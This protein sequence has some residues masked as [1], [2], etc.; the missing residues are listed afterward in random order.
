M[1]PSLARV[2]KVGSLS[3]RSERQLPTV[4]RSP[5]GSRGLTTGVVGGLGGC[6]TGRQH[7]QRN[8]LFFFFLNKWTDELPCMGVGHSNVLEQVV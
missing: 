5:H 4:T 7:L 2:S 1:T 8:V 3:S 6:V